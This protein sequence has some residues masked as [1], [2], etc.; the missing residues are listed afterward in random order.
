MLVA[1]TLRN[2]PTRLTY[3]L[4]AHQCTDGEFIDSRNDVIQFRVVLVRR[5]WI[6]ESN[7]I[8]GTRHGLFVELVAWH[9]PQFVIEEFGDLG[10]P[11]FD[12]Q[13]M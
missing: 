12:I 13:R 7:S 10:I 4:A 3:I 6:A 2:A 1:N 11:L 9:G 5:G 8:K